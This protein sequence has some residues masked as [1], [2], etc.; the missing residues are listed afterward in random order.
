MAEVEAV[1]DLAHE[2]ESLYE[3]LVDR[4]YNHSEALAQVCCSTAMTGWR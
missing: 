3:G 2:L 4:R 1:G